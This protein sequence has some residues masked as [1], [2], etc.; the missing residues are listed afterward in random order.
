M[1]KLSEKYHTC[2][3]DE[4]DQEQLD[5]SGKLVISGDPDKNQDCGYRQPKYSVN[6]LSIRYNPKEVGEE[7]I[8]KEQNLPAEQCL[9]IFKKISDSTCKLL[10]TLI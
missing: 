9:A 7:E 1:V 4:E 6:K 2:R 8:A 3:T 5:A 10:G